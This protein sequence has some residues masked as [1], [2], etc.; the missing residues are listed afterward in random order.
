MGHKVFGR[1]PVRRCVF[2]SS[3]DLIF[4]G[5]LKFG[6]VQFAKEIKMMKAALLLAF[7]AFATA[8]I[9]KDEG[10]LVLT[11][12]NFD[13]AI[14]DNEFLL[15]E[16]Y[17]PWCGHC[18]ALAPEYAKAAS[19]LAEK[20][21]KI[22]LGK[23]DAT[24]QGKLAEKFEVRGYPTLKFFRNGK[25]MEYSGGRTADTIVSWLEKKTGP[26]ALALADVEA[27]KKFVADNKVAVVGFFK[28]Q[29]TEAAK[30][31]LEVAASLDDYKFG[32]TDSDDVN[33]E[34]GVSGDKIVLFKAFDE[35]KNEFDGE[36]TAEAVQKF[37]EANAMPLVVEF[38]HE[39]AQKIFSGAIK[40]HLLLFVSYKSDDFAAQKE[41]ASKIA[42]DHKGQLLFVTVD[43]D[44]EDH[45]RI[46]EFFGI[47][48]DELPGM[49]L[50]KL[51]EDMAKYKP[52]TAAIDEDAIRAFVKGYLDG[53]LKQHLLSEEIPEDWDKEAVKVLVGKNFEEVA[54]DANKHVL[55]E[56]Y[57]P[58][59]GHCKQLV[60]VWE[61][62]GEKFKDSEDIVIAKM[63]STANELEDIKIQ[64]FPTIKLYKKGDN[65]VVDYDGE[66]TLEGLSTFLAG[67]KIF[68]PRRKCR[69]FLPSP[70]LPPSPPASSP[71]HAH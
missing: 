15:V 37:V 59:C 7:V 8:E 2:F 55:V 40:S 53:T 28:D 47:K 67:K 21:S 3:K 14:A 63:D 44:E 51:E 26:P 66:R 36:Y 39:S 48:D 31:F 54:K 11:E 49:R 42:K 1:D 19:T 56:F 52:A 70:S 35:G 30:A 38:N 6:V 25:P 50:I 20:E 22:V 17:A 9:T 65:K 16:F 46:L 24:E 58:W 68:P 18:K 64:G 5:V 12:D 62:L 13:G 61:K 27:A 41:T 43:T 57:A 23:V 71:G 69:R 45:K 4:K 29:T 33:A 10:V 32:I 60:P 34:Y